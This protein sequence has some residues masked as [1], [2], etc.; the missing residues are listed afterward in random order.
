[1]AR[2]TRVTRLPQE[3]V[4]AREQ[5]KAQQGSL[6]GGT[7]VAAVTALNRSKSEHNH[8]AGNTRHSAP[9]RHS[10]LIATIPAYRMWPYSD[11]LSCPLKRSTVTTSV[12]RERQTELTENAA[13]LT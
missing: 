2:G 7:V 1:M 8:R 5:P 10:G 12:R 6:S 11:L 13:P 9:Y 4:W 3:S